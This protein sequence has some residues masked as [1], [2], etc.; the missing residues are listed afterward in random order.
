MDD[1]TAREG[2]DIFTTL[3]KNVRY[4]GYQA[5]SPPQQDTGFPE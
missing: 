5:C 3:F 1:G 2:H 4:E